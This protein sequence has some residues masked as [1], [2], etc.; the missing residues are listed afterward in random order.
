MSY[1]Y[2]VRALNEVVSLTRAIRCCAGDEF[3]SDCAPIS[4]PKKQR[5]KSSEGS[6]RLREHPKPRS[7][8]GH[9]LHK[10]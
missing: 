10:I 8:N 9:L 1:S 6:R 2:L 5:Y 3:K 4:A 7:G